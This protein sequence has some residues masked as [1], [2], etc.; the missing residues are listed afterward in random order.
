ML[1]VNPLKVTELCQVPPFTRYSQPEILFNV[2]LVEV[3]LAKVGA[4]GAV[5]VALA[6][7]AVAAEVTVP[8][9]FAADTITV[10]TLSIS[11]ATKV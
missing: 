3:L 11:A 7:T 5:C 1:G 10:I 4:A 2:T 9:Q 6:T 8:L